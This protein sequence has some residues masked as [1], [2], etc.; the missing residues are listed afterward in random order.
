MTADSAVLNVKERKGDVMKSRLLLVCSRP[1]LPAM[2][3]MVVALGAH[4]QGPR[5]AVTDLGALGGTYS[6]AYGMNNAGVVSGGAATPSQT[7]GL[8]QTAVLWYRGIP[9]INLGTLGGAAC[10]TCNSEAGGPNAAGVSALISETA[11][12]DPNGED[13]CAFGTHR[14]CLA[15]IW[16]NGML[17][18]LPLLA[19]GSNSQ[20]LWINNRGEIAGFS[21]TG[22]QD[23]TCAS[24]TP[25]QLL[26]IE[27]VIW[28]PDGQI[29]ELAPLPGDTIS[30]ALGINENGQSVGVSGLCSNTYFPFYINPS[31]RASHGVLWDKDGTPTDLGNLG[32]AT[33]T[34]PAA[35]NDQ[36]E[37]VGASKV[38]DGTVHPFLW[39]RDKGMQDLGEPEG[40]FATGIPCCHTINN[41]G[42][43]VGFSL[44]A[45]GPHA[46]L[47]KRG[48][49]IDLNSVIPGDSGWTLLFTQSI[50][51]R[52]Q[53]AGW[54]VNPSGEIHGYLLT[55]MAE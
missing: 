18:A 31:A 22:V 30:F 1:A 52:G 34:V 45:S 35:I 27:G 8:S 7:D 16:K 20:A 14:Q 33:F 36:G 47:W 3:A 38:A 37:V 46:F 48:Q 49:M 21:E 19:G 5:Y 53:I 10:P 15:A 32:N 54:G 50:N 51:D 2:L 41:R 9:P 29:R 23:P 43:I 44:G 39:T 42:E 26:Q 55:P 25:Y 24:I 17:S 11:N 40:A 28:R 13:V 6:Y 12:P 4:A